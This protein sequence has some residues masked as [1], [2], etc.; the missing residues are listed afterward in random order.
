MDLLSRI[1]K[2]IA[3]SPLLGKR[4]YCAG[5]QDILMLSGSP[6]NLLL[7]TGLSSPEDIRKAARNL[8]TS[9]AWT[10]LAG[11]FIDRNLTVGTLLLLGGDMGTD[12]ESVQKLTGELEGI[13]AGEVG[14]EDPVEIRFFGYRTLAHLF[15]TYSWRWIKL[16][17]C[18]SLVVVLLLTALVL[19]RLR[20]VLIIALLMGGSSLC[21]LGLLQLSGIYLSV[22]LIFPLVFAVCIGSDYGLHL[23]CS[24][25]A[26][27]GRGDP[28]GA[29][30][31]GRRVWST[32]GRAIA[33][34]AFTDAGVFLAFSRMELV[35]GSQIMM[36]VALAV[37]AV[38]AS[39][40]I[41]VPALIE[42][43]E[44]QEHG[45]G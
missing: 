10:P 2:R 21:W 17:A 8:Y 22:F 16:T 44:Q 35:S 1:K 9:P 39:T 36:A 19:R 30:E 34:A 29:G 14:P 12:V 20:D 38:F 24:F 27:A 31:T 18:A 28:E 11:L 33:I 45:K 4:Y 23:L 32:T 37:L 7:G 3:A 40:I 26:G 6:L 42:K 41:L 25:R 13:I 43:H 15:S 5:V